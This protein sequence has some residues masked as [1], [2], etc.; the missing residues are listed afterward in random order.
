MKSVVWTRPAQAD[1]AAIDD[2]YRD[3]APDYADRTGRAALAAG[4]F[5][6]GYPAAGPVVGDGGVRKWR[7]RGGDYLLFYRLI[8]TGIEILRVRHGREDWP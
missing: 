5:L 8:S 2:R 4:W 7:V 3:I 1:L 6:A